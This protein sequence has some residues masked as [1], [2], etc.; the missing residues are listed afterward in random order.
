MIVSPDYAGDGIP[1]KGKGGALLPWIIE[2][3]SPEE[4][5]KMRAAGKLARDVLDMAGRAVK[6]GI[7]TDEIDTLVHEMI[8]EVRRRLTTVRGLPWLLIV[9]LIDPFLSFFSL[10]PLREPCAMFSLP[11]LVR[12]LRP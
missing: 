4:I 6:V 5:E 1:K 8:L 2:V 10:C 11:R 9:C 12:I 7:S 3:K